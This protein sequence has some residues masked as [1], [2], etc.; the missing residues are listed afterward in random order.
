MLQAA[1]SLDAQEAEARPSSDPLPAAPSIEQQ[2]A[3]Q[4]SNSCW[5][6]DPHLASVPGQE[7]N[8]AVVADSL[9]AI[10]I[11]PQKPSC[12]RSHNGSQ[13]VGVSQSEANAHQASQLAQ[14]KELHPQQLQEARRDQTLSRNTSEGPSEGWQQ[15]NGHAPQ[16]SSSNGSLSV[17]KDDA[18]LLDDMQ[19]FASALGCDWQVWLQSLNNL[20]ADRLACQAHKPHLASRQL[21]C[22]FM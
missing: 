12:R 17:D 21:S 15:A 20:H 18:A 13:A 1:D 10:P 3:G 9:H 11:P 16:E 7:S 22:L 14:A 5:S 19:G 6:A 8:P 4:S 2:E